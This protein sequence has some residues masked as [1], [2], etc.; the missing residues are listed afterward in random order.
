MSSFGETCEKKFFERTF[1]GHSYDILSS[2]LRLKCVKNLVT[3]TPKM[4]K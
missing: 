3:R 4:N 1:P 2:C